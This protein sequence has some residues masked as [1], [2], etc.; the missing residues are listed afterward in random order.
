MSSATARTVGKQTSSESPEVGGVDGGDDSGDGDDDTTISVADSSRGI[1]NTTVDGEDDDTTTVGAQDGEAT[2]L[3][4]NEKLLR[5]RLRSA[6]FRDACGHVGIKPKSLLPH[7]MEGLRASYPSS[8]TNKE[9]KLRLKV[10]EKDR[11]RLIKA[12]LKQ[13]VR[14]GSC[15]LFGSVKRQHMSALRMTRG[16]ALSCHCVL[17]KSD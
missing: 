16:C 6:T 3:A 2:E 17:W 10:F 9:I 12:V 14:G 7:T 13:E 1:G 8:V 15:W 5:K 11:R 4:D